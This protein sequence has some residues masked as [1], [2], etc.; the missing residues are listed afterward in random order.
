MASNVSRIL[1]YSRISPSIRLPGRT[2]MRSQHLHHCRARRASFLQERRHVRIYPGGGGGGAQPPHPRKSFE[3]EDILPI[4]TE[5][6]KKEE[7]T[8]RVFQDR[9]RKRQETERTR[10]WKGR[11]GEKRGA[12]LPWESAR[13]YVKRKDSS[14]GGCGGAKPPH[15]TGIVKVVNFQHFWGVRAILCGKNHMFCN[16]ERKGAKREGLEPERRERSRSRHP[17]NVS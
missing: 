10:H 5:R 3:R 14:E 15:P 6:S 1:T 7:R 16:M 13:A 17:T 2:Y 12:N 11:G 4:E 9:K 8:G